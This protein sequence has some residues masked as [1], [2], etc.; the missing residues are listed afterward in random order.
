MDTY[1]TF[2]THFIN[3]CS[4]QRQTILGCKFHFVY[5][6]L[7]LS[8]RSYSTKFTKICTGKIIHIITRTHI[9]YQF[10]CLISCCSQADQIL[11]T[12]PPPNKNV[13]E[14]DQTVIRQCR[15]FAPFA[16]YI[17]T[18]L[19][20]ESLLLITII[21]LKCPLLLNTHFKVAIIA[22]LIILNF[23]Q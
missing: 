6:F 21:D 19:F 9:H 8:V 23:T 14:T 2:L 20:L 22:K 16:P 4:K 5:M 13:T 1:I 3:L 10:L 18:S 17:I 11:P 12:F 7:P 15:P